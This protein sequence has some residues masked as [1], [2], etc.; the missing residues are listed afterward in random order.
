VTGRTLKAVKGILGYT[1]TETVMLDF[2]KTSFKTVRYWARRVC[3]WF[4]LQGFI[5]ARSSSGNYHV[6]FNRP[7]S[8]TLNTSIMAWTCLET[9]FHKHLTRWFI[10]Q[11]IKQASTLRCGRKGEKPC[12]RVVFRQGKQDS[13]IESYLQ[14]RRLIRKCERED[15]GLRKG[16][17]ADC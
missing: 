10:M 11:C 4:K 1:A 17:C 7:V 6:V 5:I 9:K 12:P 13:E 14:Y 3:R 8:W 2:D 15:T 16:A